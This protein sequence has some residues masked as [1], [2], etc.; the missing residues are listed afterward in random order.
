MLVSSHLMSELEGTADHLLVIRRGRL[1]ADAAVGELLAGER[2][3][4]RTPG[5][6]PAAAA[7]GQRGRDRRVARATTG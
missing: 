7:A 1:V 6:A 4:V 5:A 2:V 3:T